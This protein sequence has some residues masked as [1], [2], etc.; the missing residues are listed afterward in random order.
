MRTGNEKK[1][2]FDRIMRKIFC[3]GGI[4]AFA[5]GARFGAPRATARL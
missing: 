5:G 1:G 2:D 4:F 3:R